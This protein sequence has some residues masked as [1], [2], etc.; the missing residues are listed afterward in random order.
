[1]LNIYILFYFI[2]NYNFS[3][4]AM[5]IT[6]HLHVGKDFWIFK[7]KIKFHNFMKDD[8][9]VEVPTG[10]G[11]IKILLLFDRVETRMGCWNQ[12]TC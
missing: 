12:A 3:L 8:V 10:N 5:Y 1:M 7:N 2:I 6:P 4:D 11:T 9:N